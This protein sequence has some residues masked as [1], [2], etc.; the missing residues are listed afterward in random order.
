MALRSTMRSMCMESE[1]QIPRCPVRI[2]IPG[3]VGGHIA[4][5][6]DAGV[7]C[8]SGDDVIALIVGG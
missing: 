1:P 4:L 8:I 5:A 7:G 3:G 2:M 6:A